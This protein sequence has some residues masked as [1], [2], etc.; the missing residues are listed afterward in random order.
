MLKTLPKILIYSFLIVFIFQ[1]ASLLFLLL[2]PAPSQAGEIK[3]TP[4]VDIGEDYKKG[5]KY[6][7]GKEITE[8]DKKIFQSDLLPKY[9]RAIYKYAIGIVGILATVVLMFG[10]ILW[11]V[12]G[13]NAERV[14]NAK[15]WIGASLTGLILVLCSYMILKTINPALVSFQPIEVKK[16]DPLETNSSPGWYYAWISYGLTGVHSGENGPFET[17]NLCE[18]KR[19]IDD[20]R[21]DTSAGG[22]CYEKGGSSS[23]PTKNTL[24]YCLYKTGVLNPA[25]NNTY[26]YCKK[27]TLGDCKNNFNGGWFKINQRDECM[28]AAKYIGY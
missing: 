13:G 5:T 8:G 24:G 16:V 3:F 17:K 23:A 6:P 21:L 14:G 28:K 27:M 22:P 12:A 10:G 26:L 9:I 1:L 2:A 11:I 7:V 4:Q 18:K 20:N 15:S 25:T 19:K